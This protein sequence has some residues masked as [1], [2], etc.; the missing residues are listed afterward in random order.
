VRLGSYVAVE[1]A[2]GAIALSG[3]VVGT[4]AVV[5]T[6]APR[7]HPPVPVAS[8]PAVAAV[9]GALLAPQ[10][11]SQPAV[12]PAAPALPADPSI[13]ATASATATTASLTSI[14]TPRSEAGEPAAIVADPRPRA[15]A[16]E[17][18]VASVYGATDAE[19]L[20]PLRDSAVVGCKANR[21][22]TS[23]SLRLEFQSGGRAAFK[24]EQIHPQS[25]PRREI[26]AFRIDRMLG[27]GR[28]PPA[29]AIA[30][31]WEQLLAAVAPANRVEVITRLRAEARPRRGL[32]RG[33]ASWWIPEIKVAAIGKHPID[34]TDGIVTW[35]RYLTIGAVRSPEVAELVAQI[36]DMVLFDFLIDN[37]D[38][39]SGGNARTSMDGR[40]L[41][42]M[43]N[44]LSFTRNKQAHIRTSTYLHRVQVFSRRLVDR[45]RNFT[46][47]E[48]VEAING[49]DDAILAPLLTEE[50]LN[51]VMAR[52]ALAV[53][54][55]DEQIATHGAQ[56]V[57]AFP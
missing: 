21:G 24:P 9:P 18:P 27:I 57:L 55:L 8:A 15:A 45:V 51:A 44:T 31:S 4:I 41:Y 30:V 10:V 40:I 42:F 13:S 47:E 19:L 48:L 1:L 14:A 39:W 33:V 11:R 34:T 54:Y 26:A 29:T 38:R 50:E 20:A 32:L 53:A 5:S 2:V 6:L 28:V 35:K 12:T 7:P 25:Q 52:R 37:S 17:A 36:S 16:T 46:R 3:V 49:A 43:D 23:L 22:G 56:Q